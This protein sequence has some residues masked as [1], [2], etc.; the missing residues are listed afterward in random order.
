M[1]SFVLFRLLGKSEFYR[2]AVLNMKM[3]IT[4]CL[5]L[6]LTLSLVGCSDKTMTFDIGNATQIE[7]KSGLTGD[8]VIIED[9]AFVKGVTE[10]INSL[11][12]EKM[13]KVDGVGYAYMLTWTDETDRTVASITITEENGYQIS[14]DGYYYKVGADLAIDMQPILE[15]PNIALSSSQAPNDTDEINEDKLKYGAWFDPDAD[16]SEHAVVGGEPFTD[17]E[18]N[19]ND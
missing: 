15:M 16:N 12:F 4:L 1:E 9:S 7:I 6:V 13:G 10:N 8:E 17:T 18:T 19:E 14:H 5:A 11:T 2:K 3:F